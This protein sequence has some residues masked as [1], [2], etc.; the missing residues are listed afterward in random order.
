MQLSCY[1]LKHTLYLGGWGQTLQR[2]LLKRRNAVAVIPYDPV[3]DKIILIEQF[4]IGAIKEGD[5]AWLTEIV[6]GEIEE[7]ELPDAVARRE[8]QE[9]AG[10][11]IGD[12][13]H[14]LDFYLSPGGSTEKISLFCGQVD[15]TGIGGVHGLAEEG[16]DIKVTVVGFGEAIEMLNQGLIQSAIPIVGIQWLAMNRDR[17]RSQWNP[18]KLA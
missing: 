17:I 14:C 9:E 13:H 18:D 15:A 1:Q 8:T 5:A 6:A 2:E 10:C 7:G 4:R 3:N 11:S 16:E 12:L